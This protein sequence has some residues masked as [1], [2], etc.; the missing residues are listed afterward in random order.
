MFP[1]DVDIAAE[2]EEHTIGLRE[3]DLLLGRCVDESKLS[4]G[5]EGHA[6]CNVLLPGSL[7]YGIIGIGL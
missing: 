5:S 3:I 2:G 6:Y 4:C 7:Y 1:S